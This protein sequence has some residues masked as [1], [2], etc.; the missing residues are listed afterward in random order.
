MTAEEH[1][2]FFLSSIVL[3]GD[4]INSG[5]VHEDSQV[6]DVKREKGKT[7]APASSHSRNSIPGCGE[8]W[9]VE[10]LRMHSFGVGL[11]L[12][13]AFSERSQIK[14]AN[15]VQKTSERNRSNKRTGSPRAPGHGK[16]VHFGQRIDSSRTSA[17]AQSDGSL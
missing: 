1:R 17:V 8:V 15:E 2:Y 4:A 5:G 6:A 10:R 9:I 3:D 16:P 11:T 13:I 12:R 7:R 14:L